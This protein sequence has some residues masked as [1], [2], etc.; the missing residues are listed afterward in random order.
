MPLNA[1]DLQIT[2]LV[3]DIRAC[4]PRITLIATVVNHGR[5]GIPAGRRSASIIALMSE[6]EVQT[7]Q[8]P[9]SDMIGGSAVGTP[10]NLLPGQSTNVSVVYDLDP[11]TPPIN[12]T[13]RAVANPPFV[14][15]QSGLF[16]CDASNNS[17]DV[18]NVDCV[19]GGS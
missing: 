2:E 18:A 12:L 9:A 1:P 7:A 5:A 3:A 6:T 4:P 10:V 11:G 16:E 13:F 14:A 15:N 19:D 8:R 17:K